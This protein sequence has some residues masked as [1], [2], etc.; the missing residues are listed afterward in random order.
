MVGKTITPF[1]DTNGQLKVDINVNV[2]DSQAGLYK[3]KIILGENEND[4]QEIPKT[5][6]KYSQQ[7]TIDIEGVV[8]GTQ[9][10]IYVQDAIGNEAIIDLGIITVQNDIEIKNIN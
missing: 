2:K 1:K 9:V 6:G 5:S 10:K 8:S 3:Y 7:H 4:W